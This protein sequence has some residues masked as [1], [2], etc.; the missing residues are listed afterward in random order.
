MKRI[1]RGFFLSF[2][3][4]A[5]ASDNEFLFS[6]TYPTEQEVTTCCQASMVTPK[7]SG[8]QDGTVSRGWQNSTGDQYPFDHVYI[9][10]DADDKKYEPGK[11]QVIKMPIAQSSQNSVIDMCFQ[12]DE[13]P[14]PSDPEDDIFITVD[15]TK[16]E[17]DDCIFSSVQ[18]GK[19]TM[20]KS[21]I[22]TP[23]GKPT[24]V[25]YGDKL[26]FSDF[27]EAEYQIEKNDKGETI[28]YVELEVKHP[29]GGK[30][31]VPISPTEK[32]F[33]PLNR[34]TSVIRGKFVIA[35]LNS[36]TDGI[37]SYSAEEFQARFGNLSEWKVRVFLE[38]APTEFTYANMKN[39]PSG[40]DIIAL[41][42]HKMGLKPGIEHSGFSVDENNASCNGVGMIDESVAHIFPFKT[43]FTVKTGKKGKTQ[44]I[45]SNIC[46]SFYHKLPGKGSVEKTT[47]IKVPI[48][49]ITIEPN[50]DWLITTVID[51]E[52][53]ALG[54]NGQTAASKSIQSD[55][56]FGRVM[57]V[58]YKRI[59]LRK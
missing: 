26:F 8:E 27:F 10:S 15:G 21:S 40:T 2:L 25:P 38:N 23:G 24:Y 45:I 53:F 43:D 47:T 6:D 51:V 50:E 32:L 17:V 16:V 34:Y 12:Y 4:A 36:L 44:K 31:K 49:D 14:D 42:Q 48:N 1:F 46:Y 59:I 18:S 55:S 56:N 37:Y 41:S 39:K 35:N 58:P 11:I 7:Q 54:I 13:G 30:E 3:L 57:Q 22:V 19:G 5:C 29:S 52:D 28:K 33:I 20:K 9:L